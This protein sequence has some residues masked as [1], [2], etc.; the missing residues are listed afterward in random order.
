MLVTDKLREDSDGVI[1]LCLTPD[2]LRGEVVAP[3]DLSVEET[4]IINHLDIHYHVPA[5]PGPDR[6]PKVPQLRLLKPGHHTIEGL[7]GK[8]SLTR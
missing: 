2:I 8:H 3:D 1:E 7:E 6:H 5:V 4:I